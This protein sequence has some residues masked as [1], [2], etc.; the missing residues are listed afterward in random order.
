MPDLNLNEEGAM[1][2][3]TPS[4]QPSEPELRRPRHAAGGQAVRL[5]I[6]FVVL[7]VLAGAAY[8]L[9]ELGVVKLWG[10][11][12]PVVARVEEPTPQAPAEQAPAQ[13]PVKEPA[14]AE[15]KKEEPKKE[16]T[17]REEPKPA[18]AQQPAKQEAKPAAPPVAKQEA[19]PQAPVQEQPKPVATPPMEQ[20]RVAETKK[21]D[22]PPKMLFRLKEPIVFSP[23]PRPQP[24]L[25]MQATTPAMKEEP[26]SKPKEEPRPKEPAPTLKMSVPQQPKA[27][28]KKE[29]PSQPVQQAAAPKKETSP[30][31]QP[32]AP[33]PAEPKK[34]TVAQATPP[35]QEAPHKPK[36][37]APKAAAPKTETMK[38]TYTVQVYAFREKANADAVVKR[39]T[40]N[41]YP[42]FIEPI[43]AKGMTWYTVRIGRYPSASE[44][45][46]AVENFAQEIKEH[47]FIDKVRTKEN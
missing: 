47:H 13:Q 4:E 26:L 34:E 21:A 36:E 37:E 39:L 35:K 19:K 16:P 28:P 3:Q 14:K 40:D 5:V 12:E 33:K 6:I 18:V 45:K 41:G 9:N 23:K 10:S 27:E 11:K 31:Q 32:A 43:E 2:E 44:A 30:Q 42:A 1:E 38:G 17:K 20:K 29:T 22:E 15:P 7:G 24:T 46:K 25:A 8:M